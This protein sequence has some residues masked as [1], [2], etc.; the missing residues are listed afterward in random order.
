M[1]NHLHQKIEGNSGKPYCIIN[2]RR[3]SSK[4]AVQCCNTDRRDINEQEIDEELAHIHIQAGQEVHDNRER[5]NLDE[6]QG[7]I[8]H[9]PRDNDG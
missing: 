7:Q 1:W 9:D 5:N 8:L 4:H 2:R 6:D 3:Q